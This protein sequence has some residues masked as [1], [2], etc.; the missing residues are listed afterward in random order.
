MKNYYQILEVN[1]NSSVEEIKQAYRNLAKKYHPDINKSPDAQQRFIEISEA[2]EVLL[3]LAAEQDETQQQVDYE[4]FLRDIREAAKKQARL[5][6]EKFERQHEAF[7]ESGLYD[8]GLLFKY[9]GKI[10]LPIISLVMIFI[11]FFVCISEHSILPFFYLFFFWLIGGILLIYVYQE[12]DKYFRVGKFYYSYRKIKELY[13]KTNENITEECFYCEGLKANSISFKLELVEVKDIQLRNDG[14]MQHQAGYNRKNITIIFPRSQKAFVIHSLASLIKLCSIFGSL[15]FLSISSMVWRFIGGIL[16]GW[17]LSSALLLFSQTRSKTAYLIS[18]GMFIKIILW[19]GVI[20]T[21]SVFQL[22]PF[23]IN[24]T[25]FINFGVVFYLI[26][27]AI[28]EQI[29]KIPKKFK[30]FMPLP[31]QYINL[32]GH[33]EKKC[34]LYLEIPFWTTIY[35]FFRWL[36]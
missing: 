5:R 28:I 2:Y 22:S 24:T 30:L 12:K 31:K 7:R 17:M 36:F 19:L 20:S 4:D 34:M 26:F 9:I 8:V 11:P 23:N 1:E 18:Y 25:P 3:Q 27:D 14:P 10:L 13:L 35:P 15:F 6:Y 29:L 16:I 33:F 21:C 32:M